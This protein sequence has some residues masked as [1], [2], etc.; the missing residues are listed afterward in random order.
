MH[1]QLVKL[2]TR[3]YNG[4]TAADY[5]SSIAPLE[6]DEDDEPYEEELVILQAFRSHEAQAAKTARA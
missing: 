3:L 5:A 4:V 6:G 2:F 1:E